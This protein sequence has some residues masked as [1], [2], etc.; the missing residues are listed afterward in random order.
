MSSTYAAPIVLALF[1]GLGQAGCSPKAPGADEAG[2]A[3]DTTAQSASVD[4]VPAPSQVDTTLAPTRNAPDTS[5]ATPPI[6]PPPPDARRDTPPAGAAKPSPQ[7]GA[8]GGLKVSQ[9]EYEGWR[10]YSVHCARCHGQDVLGNPVA[11]DLLVSLGPGGPIDT[12]EKFFQVV[13][14]GRPDRGMPALKG[15]MTPEQIRAV[16]AYVKGRAE[17]RIPAGRPASPQG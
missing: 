15:S 14:E 7:T 10:Q 6:T 3:P 2:P 11:S 1:I 12:P 17:K 4:T 8:G 16:Y 5:V 13:S 9:L